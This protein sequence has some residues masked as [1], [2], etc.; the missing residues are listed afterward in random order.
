MAVGGEG[1]GQIKALSRPGT[2]F[3]GGVIGTRPSKRE[4]GG[5]QAWSERPVRRKIPRTRCD[6][7]RGGRGR[8]GC[9]L[10]PA[11]S[12]ARAAAARAAARGRTHPSGRPWGGRGSRGRR[13]GRV[14][15]RGGG[16]RGRGRPLC[17]RAASCRG[18]AFPSDRWRHKG[19]SKLKERNSW[20][21]SECTNF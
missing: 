9:H 4:S 8:R 20:N 10:A 5:S 6:P 16:R 21:R 14:C 12:T 19:K 3:S 7:G 15:G 11:E 13:C 1:P 2:A 17:V 18:S